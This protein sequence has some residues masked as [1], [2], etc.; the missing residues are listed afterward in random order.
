MASELITHAISSISTSPPGNSTVVTPQS[1]YAWWTI[2]K[3]YLSNADG[4]VSQIVH[5]L[6]N[7]HL[8]SEA[9]AVSGFRQL[10]HNHPV[11][12]LLKPHFQG[13]IGINTAGFELLTSPNGAVTQVAGFGH[14]GLID[15]VKIAYEDWSFN[16][17]DFLHDL[18]V[19]HDCSLFIKHAHGGGGGGGGI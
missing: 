14:S 11:H 5:H 3:L 17:T 2:A 15:L 10:S 4:L 9:F 13:L 18:Q 7:A 16:K 6:V 1:G 8:I 19:K 12:K